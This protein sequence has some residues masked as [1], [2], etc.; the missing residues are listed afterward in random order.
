MLKGVTTMIGDAENFD[1]ELNVD[2]DGNLTLCL[3]W[4]DFIW[5]Y[6]INKN[7]S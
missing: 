2:D 6:P 7:F 1:I 3:I 4:D 5:L